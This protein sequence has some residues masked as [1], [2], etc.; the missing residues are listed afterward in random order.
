MYSQHISTHI[1]GSL[2]QN[3]QGLTLSHSLMIPSLP[4]PASSYA[5]RTWIVLEVYQYPPPK[6][7]C[8]SQDGSEE[9]GDEWRQ[10][11]PKKLQSWEDLS[12]ESRPPKPVLLPSTELRS[13]KTAAG[14]TNNSSSPKRWTRGGAQWLRRVPSAKGATKLGHME[15][16]M[17][18]GWVR[19]LQNQPASY[20]R[21]RVIETHG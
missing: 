19:E 6:E 3:I 18:I 16:G 7:T 13:A 4:C 20:H 1:T 5:V 15:Y 2:F 14:S 11:V 12:T 10:K 17:N 21:I 9:I 8:C